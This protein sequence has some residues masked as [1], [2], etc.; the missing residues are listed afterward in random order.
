MKVEKSE[1]QN[2]IH[3]MWSD[4]LLTNVREGLNYITDDGHLIIGINVA[5]RNKNLFIAVCIESGQVYSEF[6]FNDVYF[7]LREVEVTLTYK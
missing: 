4:L 5:N 1:K 6:S 2:L 7:P 3:E